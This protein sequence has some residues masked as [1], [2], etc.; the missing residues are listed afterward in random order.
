LARDAI[1][2]V[3]NAAVEVERVVSGCG[4]LNLAGIKRHVG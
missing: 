3:S 1:V 4:L 2:G